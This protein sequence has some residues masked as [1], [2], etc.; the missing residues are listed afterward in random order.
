MA[1][2]KVKEKKATSKGARAPDKIN[3][4]DIKGDVAGE[5]ELPEVFAADYRPDLIRRATDAMAANARQPYAPKPTAGMRHSVQTW[6]KGRGVSRVQRLM[7]S[8]TAAQSPNNVGGRRAHPPRVAKDRGKKINR[9]ELLQAKLAALHATSVPELVRGRGHRFEEELTVPVVVRDD[10][11]S[12]KTTKDA[13]DALSSI[14]VY[15]DVERAKN[16]R[17]IRAGRGKMRGR[18]H[19]APRGLLVVLS[20]ECEGGRSMRNIAGVEVVTPKTLNV[21]VLAP[22]GDPGRLM[23]VS[24]SALSEIGRWSR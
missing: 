8:S 3:V 6:G 10:L 18:K 9:K 24:E 19:R 2:K 17:K 23:M 14:G 7:G 4:Y 13:I 21:S 12:I 5:A 15:D 16:G 1:E 22:G 20:G 11:E